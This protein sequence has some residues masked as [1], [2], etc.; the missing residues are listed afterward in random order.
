M[1]DIDHAD[2]LDSVARKHP[3]L[4][5]IAVAV[6]V[7]LGRIADSVTEFNASANANLGPLEES[8][9]EPLRKLK[10][11]IIERAAQQKSN[12]IPPNCPDCETKLVQ[13]RQV[14][15]EFTVGGGAINVKRPIGFCRRCDRSC[16]PA[17]R[18]LGL[19]GG[20]SPLVQEMA[21][22]FVSKVPVAEASVVMRRATGIALPAATLDRVVKR[23]AQKAVETRKQADQEARAGGE[24]LARQSVIQAP[25]TLIILMDDWNIRER[26]HWGEA[27]KLRK[28]GEEPKHWHWVWTG[29]VFGLDKRLKKKGR[30]KISH[31]GYVATREGVGALSEQLHAEA[32]RQGLGRA[33][34]VVVIA[35][36]A[37]WIWNVAADRFQ[38]AVQRVDIFHVKQH[39]WVAARELYPDPAQAAQWVKKMKNNLKRGRA[40]KVVSSLE[41]AAKELPG[42]AKGLVAKQMA[43][44]KEH[45]SRMDYAK[46]I[47]RGE[48]IGSGAI[49]STCHQYQC[50]FKRTGQFW[51]KEGD[52]GL[53]CVETFW[54][55]NRWASLFPHAAAADSSKN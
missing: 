18:A 50:R 46:G 6:R 44:I 33:K 38:G 55:N 27:E 24:A 49:E 25:E 5:E 1:N 36:G 26:S 4:A 53:M 45:E 37:A 42:P 48:P 11:S 2:N 12:S 20:Y 32:L 9:D 54:R 47:A 7:F 19:E 13:R 31:R 10:A 22:L 3:F 40:G 14:S 30:A 16:C 21:A 52:E 51:T 41:E 8:L 35:D 29:T 17:D 39:L 28:K 15:R 23:V 34:R 43:Y